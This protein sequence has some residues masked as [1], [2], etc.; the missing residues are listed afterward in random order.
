MP[1]GVSFHA[2]PVVHSIQ[3]T[4]CADV[5]L[6]TSAYTPRATDV[7]NLRSNLANPQK[8]PDTFLVGLDPQGGVELIIADRGFSRQGAESVR[9]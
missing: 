3:D 5:S 4:V 1:A 7:I 9:A 6:R 2:P 8:S